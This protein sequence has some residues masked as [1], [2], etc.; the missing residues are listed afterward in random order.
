M[1]PEFSLADRAVRFI[2]NLTL[3][4]EF[5]GQ[6]MELRPWQ[7]RIIR[8]LHSIG[9]DGLTLYRTC[10]LLIPRK[11]S[12]TQLAASIGNCHILGTGKVGQTAVVA[13]SDR[14]Q[15]GHVFRKVASQIESDP[16]L[17]RRCR[18]YYSTKRIETKRTGNVLQVLSSDGRRAHGENPSLVILDEVHTQKK[19][20]LYDA[21][22]SGFGARTEHLTLLISTQGN[23]R[24][25][26]IWELTE[27]SRKV[28]DGK[29]TNPTHLPILYEAP[30]DAD[31]MDEKVW[32]AAMPAL[33]D[34]CSLEFIRQEFAKA[35]EI[36]SEESKC[37]QLYLNQLVA[38]STK[39]VNSRKWALCGQ[40]TFDPAKLKGRKSYWGLDLSATSDITALVGVFPM[41]D[42]TFQVLCHFWIPKAYAELRAT[43]DFLPYLDWHRQGFLEFTPGDV[44][45][46]PY[47][48]ERI[49]QILRQYKTRVVHADPW[50]ATSTTQRVAAEGLPVVNFRQ[51]WMNMSPAIKQAEV[52][53]AKGLIHHGN[54]PVLNWMADNAVA[55]RDR[56]DNLTFDKLLSSD[57]IDGIVA[58]VM[59]FA[60][61]IADIRKAS[62]YGRMTLDQLLGKIE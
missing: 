8:L 61:A 7:E 57:K 53:I 25:S 45:D 50:N 34:F 58:M 13:A 49:P 46:Y 35:K 22:T 12:K 33:G 47:L 42:L 11:Q 6:P 55:H 1:A 3:T 51:N 62:V 60:G 38:A 17:S 16:F 2:N 10:L 27:Y 14:Y 44:V 59:G 23:R 31:W 9:P 20:D 54:N 5:L 26:L 29:I 32:H 24:D 4:D 48:E 28:R 39:W 19:R 21:L 37:R 56:K 41:E 43:R 40:K 30:A 15:A 36:P 52:A 18:I